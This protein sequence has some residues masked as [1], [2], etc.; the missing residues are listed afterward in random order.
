[1]P[2]IMLT[3]VDLPAPLGQRSPIILALVN[4]KVDGFEHVN[5]ARKVPESL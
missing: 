4:F 3:R 5:D 1:M 2:V